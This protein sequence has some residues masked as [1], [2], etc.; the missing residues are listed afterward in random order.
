MSE[1]LDQLQKEIAALR[2]S[3][4]IEKIL[5]GFSTDEKYRVYLSNGENRLLRI[6]KLDQWEQ[7]KAEYDIIKTIQTLG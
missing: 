5:K 6:F 1:W 4:R 2:S 3:T 7:K